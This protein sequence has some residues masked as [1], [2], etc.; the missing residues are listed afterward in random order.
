MPAQDNIEKVGWGRAFPDVRA[1]VPTRARP[2]ECAYPS[3]KRRGAGSVG[4]DGPA[5]RGTKINK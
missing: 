4:R 5:G 3:G 2:G 1:R